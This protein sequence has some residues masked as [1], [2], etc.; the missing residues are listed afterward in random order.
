MLDLVV[1]FVQEVIQELKVR[2]PLS[3]AANAKDTSKK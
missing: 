2:W 3:S 1:A